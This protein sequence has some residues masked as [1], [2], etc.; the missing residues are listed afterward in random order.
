M[1]DSQEGSGTPSSGG[2][3]TGNGGNGSSRS[4]GSGGGSSGGNRSRN[5]NRNRNRSRSSGSGGSGSGS[6][7]GSGGSGS[8]SSG[9]G[10]SGGSSSG[11]GGN[12]S[13]RSGSNGQRKGQGGGRQRSPQGSGKGGG[14]RSQSRSGSGSGAGSG[15]RQRSGPP[16]S[17]VALAPLP[18]LEPLDVAPTLGAPQVFPAEVA[19]NRHRAVTLCAVAAVLPALLLGALVWVALSMIAGAVVF[20]VAGAAVMY[21]VW[22]VAPSVALR[23]IGAAQIDEEDETRLSNVTEGLCATFGLS[24]PTFHVLDDDVPN[25]CALG[26]DARRSALIVTT[27]LLRRL[28]PIELEGVVAHELAHV[29]RGDNGVSCI[30]ITLARVFGGEATLRRCVGESREYRADVVGASAVRF[31][32][33]LLGA[34]RTMMEAPAPAAGSFFATPSRFG[35]TRWVWIDPSVGHRGDAP[36]PGDLDATSVRAAALSE[37]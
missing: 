4:G 20:V 30:G 27:G 2:A 13:A 6:G 17:G 25:A 19:A 21:V 23:R 7:S 34:L 15:S 26:R 28:D 10:R 5:R 11:G 14:N 36:V 35:P 22:R 32:R 33:G 12:A 37:W 3:S 31:P 29:K 18:P 16:R 8:S 1:A 9:G 24:M